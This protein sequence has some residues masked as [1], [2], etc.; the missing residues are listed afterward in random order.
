MHGEYPSLKNRWSPLHPSHPGPILGIGLCTRCAAGSGRGWRNGWRG[1][2]HLLNPAT[3][4]RMSLSIKAMTPDPYIGIENKF[5]VGEVYEVKI[6]K[7]TDF[8]AFA[9]LDAGI[10]GLIHTSEIKHLN[11]NVNPRTVFK[12]GDVVKVKLKELDLEKKKLV[13]SYKDTQENPI[14]L[15][16]LMRKENNLISYFIFLIK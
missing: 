5:K 4:K 16:A 6:S 2:P 1:Q 11:K 14:E 8:G 7:L 12:V 9:E 13:L 15:R 3:Q 10:A